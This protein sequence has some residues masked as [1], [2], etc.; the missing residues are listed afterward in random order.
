MCA[1]STEEQNEARQIEALKKYKGSDWRNYAVE[2]VCDYIAMGW[3]FNNYVCEYF[4]AVKDELKENLPLEYFNFIESIINIIPERLP[5]A[6]E[7]LTEEN[8]ETIY[9]LFNFRY[10]P[11][12]ITDYERERKEEKN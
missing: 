6:E 12:E 2:L 5:I 11:F 4:D 10:D 7:P 1:L 3:E 9:L 8:Y